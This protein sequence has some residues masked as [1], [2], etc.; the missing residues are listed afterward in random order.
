MVFW[1]VALVET[2]PQIHLGNILLF[3][4]GWKV[5]KVSDCSQRG[6]HQVNPCLAVLKLTRSP[7]ATLSGWHSSTR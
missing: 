4:E 5:G 1:I 6:D 3:G 7:F 2:M